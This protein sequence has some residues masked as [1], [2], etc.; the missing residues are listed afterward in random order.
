MLLMAN[1]LDRDELQRLSEVAFELSMDVLFET[2]CPAELDDLPSNA[3]IIGINSRSFE[4]GLSLR[5]FKIATFMRKW[6]GTARDH[7]VNLDRFNYIAKVPAQKI[8][9]AE[10]GISAANCRQ[11]FSLGFHSIL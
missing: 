7:S 4:G 5:N 8:K 1:S 3:K 10:S 11:V 6:L 2:H 9:V